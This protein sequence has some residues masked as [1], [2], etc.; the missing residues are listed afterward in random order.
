MKFDC[1][2]DIQNAVAL[3][4]FSITCLTVSFPAMSIDV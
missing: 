1:V 3:K 4:P 2:M